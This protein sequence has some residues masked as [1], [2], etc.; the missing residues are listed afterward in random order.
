MLLCLEKRILLLAP[1]PKMFLFL[2]RSK[3]E[4]YFL[5]S[6]VRFWCSPCLPLFFFFPDQSDL[7]NPLEGLN[8]E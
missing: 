2:S 4:V 8:L 7:F 6:N 1:A 5:C 3:G